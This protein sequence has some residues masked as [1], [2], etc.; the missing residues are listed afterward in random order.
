MAPGD[1]PLMLK[2]GQAKFVPKGSR[3]VFQMHYTPNGK[4]LKD[5]SEVGLIFAKEPPKYQV[6]TVP[7]GNPF[8]IIPAGADNHP[9]EAAYT[10]KRDG[11]AVGY[12][13][14]MHL[15][16][17]DFKIEAHYPDNR[18]EILLNVPQFNFNWQSIY[19]NVQP[20]PLPQGTKVVC[21]AHFDNSSKNPNNPDPTQDVRWGDQTWQEMMIGWIDFAV[22]R[23]K[24]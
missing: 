16:G 22:D 1:M 21:Y 7:V 17:K 10:M 8:F 23:T 18:K 5:R 15:R 12:M 4:A 24:K 19:R 14:H 9:V 2:P 13:P 11:Y 3:L 6:F 20:L